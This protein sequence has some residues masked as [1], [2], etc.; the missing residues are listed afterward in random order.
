MKIKLKMTAIIICALILISC[1]SSQPDE[2]PDSF[3]IEYIPDERRLNCKHTD[4][5]EFYNSL[6]KPKEFMLNGDI[7]G[8]IVPH[9]LAAAT[10]ISG[11]FK[12]VAESGGAYDTVVIVAPNHEGATGDI[13]VSFRDWQVWDAVYCD[14]ELVGGVYKKSPDGVV[15]TE[16]DS[17]MEDEHSVSV[18]IPYISYYLPDAKVAAFLLNRRLTLE[19]VYNFSGILSDE[20]T[21]SGKKI[22]FIGSIDFSHYLPVSLAAGNDR[23]TE[24]TIMDRNYRAIQEFSNEYVDSPQA[25]NTFLLYLQNAGMDNIEI[26]Y[27][28]DMSEFYGEGI[29]ETTSYFIIAAYEK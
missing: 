1:V 20:I 28:T 18:L 24:A 27:N 2:I 22:L 26:L 5:T 29:H 10:L 25:L 8:G 11:F 4:L 9:H 13:V 14:I 7:C 17:R 19:T 6:Q 15:I 16:N 3:G 21:A 23:I 12:A